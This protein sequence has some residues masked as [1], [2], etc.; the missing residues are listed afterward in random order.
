M[1]FA[2]DEDAPLDLLQLDRYP[3]KRCIIIDD[4]IDSGGLAKGMRAI[5]AG[6]DCGGGGDGSSSRRYSRW[7]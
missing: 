6:C 7:R 5:A 4:T 3:P 2:G 1:L